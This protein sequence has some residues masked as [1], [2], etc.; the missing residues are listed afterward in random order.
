MRG[1]VFYNLAQV[2]IFVNDHNCANGYFR[3]AFSAALLSS[4]LKLPVDMK[5]NVRKWKPFV[6]RDQIQTFIV[7]YAN[8]WRPCHNV[9]LVHNTLRGIEPS[10]FLSGKTSVLFHRINVG[11]EINT[12]HGGNYFQRFRLMKFEAIG[13]NFQCLNYIL[14]KERGG[15]LF[16]NTIKEPAASTR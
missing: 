4:I 9:L 12:I 16:N 7:K 1:P 6:Q 8:S 15:S 14:R 2:G 11:Q 10:W 5:R 3:M 13:P